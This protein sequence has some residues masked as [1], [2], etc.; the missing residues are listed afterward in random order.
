LHLD[1][2]WSKVALSSR[3]LIKGS[4]VVR[5][6]TYIY[7]PRS[8]SPTAILKLSSYNNENGGVHA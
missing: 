7:R 1:L 2:E 6:L 5:S 8:L 3:H 4:R